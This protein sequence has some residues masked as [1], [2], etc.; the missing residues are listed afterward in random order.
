MRLT[1]FGFRASFLDVEISQAVAVEPGSDDG[2]VVAAIETGGVDVFEQA[3]FNDLIRGVQ[4]R[5]VPAESA[6]QNGV[7]GRPVIRKEFFTPEDTFFGK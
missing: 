1:K 6:V 3:D 5:L 7:Y 2:I 4:S